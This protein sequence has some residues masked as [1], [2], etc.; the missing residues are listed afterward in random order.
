MG[1]WDW[2][3]SASDTVKNHTP[4]ITLATE[5]F[6]KGYYFC[7][8]STVYAAGTVS[9]KARDLHE[10]LSDNQARENLTQIAK[11]VSKNGAFYV[12]RSYGIFLFFFFFF[13]HQSCVVKVVFDMILDDHMISVCF[14][15]KIFI[16]HLVRDHVRII[17]L[18]QYFEV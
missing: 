17:Q 9:S 7:R 6:Q 14:R 2:F 10:Y 5:F 3:N 4:A 18:N 12:A 13:Y 8:D 15:V 16:L 11:N 1:L